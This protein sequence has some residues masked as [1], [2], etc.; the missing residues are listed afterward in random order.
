MFTWPIKWIIKKALVAIIPAL[1][2]MGLLSLTGVDV[3][4]YVDEILAN[5]GFVE[6]V[7]TTT[8]AE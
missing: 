8:A 5:L 2:S 3:S 4:T 6:E 1:I 7:E